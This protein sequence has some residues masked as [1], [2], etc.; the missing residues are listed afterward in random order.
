MYTLELTD[1]DIE[2]I[3]FVGG[4]YAWSYA[5]CSL[6]SGRNE[7]TE[8]DAWIIRDAIDEDMVGGHSA[9][10]MLDG[11][12]ELASKLFEFWQSII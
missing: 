3:A 12:S 6:F 5:L 10:P 4:R 11:R 7:L 1:T 2:T 9:F 8:P